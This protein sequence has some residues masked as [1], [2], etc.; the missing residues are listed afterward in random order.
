M[1]G[2]DRAAR[3][4][5]TRA[6]A[7][8]GGGC[9]RAWRG[10]CPRRR[11]GAA[12]GG[13]TSAAPSAPRISSR[14]QPVGRRPGALLVD[15]RRAPPPGAASRFRA[16][17][18]LAPA[19]WRRGRAAPAGPR[20][21][22]TPSPGARP[23]PGQRW[24]GPAGRARPRALEI[25][26]CN[27]NGL[28]PLACAQAE[29]NDPSARSPSAERTMVATASSLSAS[30]ATRTALASLRRAA[31]TSATAV[32]S[33]SRAVSTTST[34]SSS[35]R[36]ARY[37][38]NRSDEESAQWA[39]S[40]AIITGPR[41]ARFAVSQYR[42]CTSVNVRSDA[43]RPAATRVSAERAG[44][45]ASCP[46]PGAAQVEQR[47]GQRR[48]AAQQ[49]RSLGLV[50]AGQHRLEQLAHHAERELLLEF[51]AA[52]PQEPHSALLGELA[53]REQQRGLADPAGPSIRTTLPVPAAAAATAR[54]SRVELRLAFEQ[55]RRPRPPV[56]L[57]HC[58][59]RRES[60]GY[61]PRAVYV[62]APPPK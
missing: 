55:H 10:G 49:C 39:S 2:C 38:R 1:P 61:V 32:C 30:G 59:A 42:P 27:R 56:I 25:S 11:R 5:L 46:G 3:P 20:P 41:S 51:A 43:G 4:L 34:P 13:R 57:L 21:R 62:T 40:T 15:A 29:Q 28:P 14:N 17:P 36:A 48:R 52:G 16:P 58:L 47:A 9:R 22:A 60:R 37:A 19:S 6:A 12:A 8:R 31:I 53:P 26:S 35:Q 23:R 44:S 50:G 7:R 33:P 45:S 24:P 54:R 18:R